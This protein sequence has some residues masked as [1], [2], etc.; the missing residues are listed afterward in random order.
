MVFQ[1]SPL[2]PEN[3]LKTMAQSYKEKVTYLNTI[4]KTN[5]NEN[6]NFFDDGL[7]GIAAGHIMLQR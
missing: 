7:G 4:L 2:H 1:R 6:E 3:F 5:Q